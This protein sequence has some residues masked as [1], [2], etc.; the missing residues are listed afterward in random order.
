[1]KKNLL[2]LISLLLILPML[3]YSCNE[4]EGNEQD[5]E[6]TE[7][8]GEQGGGGEQDPKPAEEIEI[9]SGK[10]YLATNPNIDKY[11]KECHY[12]AH[13]WS[14][15]DILSYPGGFPDSSD[16][17]CTYYLK[18]DKK[19]TSSGS[20]LQLREYDKK[21]GTLTWSRD[22]DIDK[23]YSK[24]EISNLMP[25]AYYTYKLVANTSNETVLEGEFYTTGTLHHLLFYSDVHNCRDLG[26]W[27]TEDKTKMVKYRMIY[28]GGRLQE[29]EIMNKGKKD[30]VAEGIKAQL[31]LRGNS[32]RLLEPGEEQ[33]DPE[34]AL[35]YGPAV[36]GMDFCSPCI[37]QGGP[38][39]LGISDGEEYSAQ[40]IECFRFIF[41]CIAADKPV[42]FHCSLGRDRTGTLALLVLGLLGVDEGD[43]SKEY[44]LTYFA[45]KGWSVASSETY[46]K[47]MNNR[48]AWAY[49]PTAKAIWDNYVENG[50]TFADGVAKFL[51]TKSNGQISQTDIDAF[52]AKMLVPVP[53]A[54]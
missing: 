22:K 44:E 4:K 6:G 28:R 52:R 11:M 51:L 46:K 23:A 9:V 27:L 14:K 47:Y 26:G 19:A 35:K 5:E 34:H 1:M 13:D 54:E 29:P 16:Q 20:V 45:P 15:S 48:T 21:G 41:D 31:D 17:P 30:I 49:Q 43:I 42:Y 18:W 32:D 24:T 25:N 40:T 53:A 33:P 8:E 2:K 3:M 50:K 38:A 10:T 12:P 36:E 37:E 39:M 7:Q